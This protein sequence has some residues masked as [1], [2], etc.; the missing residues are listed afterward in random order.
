MTNIFFQSA[1]YEVSEGG[2]GAGQFC[3]ETGELPQR[4]IVIAFRFTAG[5]ALGETCLLYCL[6]T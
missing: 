6:I 3:V 1:T 5:T 4:D 2:S